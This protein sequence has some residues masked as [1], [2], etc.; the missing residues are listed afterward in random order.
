MSRLNGGIIPELGYIQLA[1]LTALHLDH[2]YRKWRKD[3][4]AASTVRAHHMIISSALT[5]AYKWGLVERSVWPDG[6]PAHRRA[7]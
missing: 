7:T 5:Q 4:L 2:A 1:K 6:H 3:G